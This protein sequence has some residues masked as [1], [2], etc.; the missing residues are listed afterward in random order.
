MP[1]ARD[2]TCGPKTARCDGPWPRRDTRQ[3]MIGRV[4]VGGGA[5][6]RVQSMTSTKTTDV[7]GT[8]SQIE[9]L[10]AAGCEIVR[11]AVPGRKAAGALGEIVR[12]SPLPVVAD[13]HFDARLAVAAIEAGAAKVRINPGNIGGSGKVDMVIAAAK[14]AGVPVRIGVNAGSLDDEVRAEGLPLAEALAE[15]AIRFVK[16]VEALGFE[17]LVISVK[18]NSVPDTVEAYRRVAELTDHPLHLG[19]TEAGTA[20][21]GAIK[22]AAGL[23]VLL[24]QG[25]G[26]TLR[27]SLTADP[28]EEVAAA[29]EILS[30]MEIRRRRPSLISCPTCGRTEIDLI[31]IAKAVEKRLAG[32][33]APLTVAVMGC[34]VNGPG[35]ARDADV[36]VAAG[37]G[38]GV[39]FVKGEP[40]KKVPEARIV[41][42][43]M[44]EVDRLAAEMADE[45]NEPY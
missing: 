9:A 30:A 32:L 33:S 4:A 45:R 7:D 17:D 1:G 5:P 2:R 20:W 24:A 34:V 13:V 43:L 11:C 25:L 19:I 3:V 36:G 39:I 23:G 18:A 6:V 28:L 16:R 29:W 40:V 37:K 35:E 22:S 27:V 15:S 38:T 44:E 41:E 14:E 21:S 8:L 12:R 42:A 26:D 31:P 10:A